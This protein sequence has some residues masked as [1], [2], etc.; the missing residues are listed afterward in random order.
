MK[1]ARLVSLS[2]LSFGL[3]AAASAKQFRFPLATTGENADGNYASVTINKGYEGQ[4]AYE[5]VP[6]T[7]KVESLLR[8]QRCKD[9]VVLDASVLD[10][11]L[12]IDEEAHKPG[13]ETVKLF[14]RQIACI[15]P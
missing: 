14:V 6:A 15:A 13:L 4:I 5:L 10:R 9:G 11:H 2:V 12:E 1:I 7:P 8:S 3:C